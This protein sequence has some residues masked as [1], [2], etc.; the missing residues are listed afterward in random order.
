MTP[1]LTI[2]DGLCIVE[3]LGHRHLR[4]TVRVE[5][6]G[7]VPMLFVTSADPRDAGT[8]HGPFGPLAIYC[9]PR[10]MTAEECSWLDKEI[11]DNERRKRED[12]ERNAQR[13]AW[14]E[15]GATKCVHIARDSDEGLVTD[16]GVLVRDKVP[17]VT[18]GLSERADCPKCAEANDIP[19]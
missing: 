13:K 9:G 8:V 10:A 16:C 2:P 7:P 14:A 18:A 11:A 17:F 12:E 5:Y 3:L 1:Q 15:D 6:L 19:W 4:G